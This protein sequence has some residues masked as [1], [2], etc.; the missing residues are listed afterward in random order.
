MHRPLVTG[1]RSPDTRSVGGWVHLGA[2]LD[3]VGGRELCHPCRES[4]TGNS[5]RS[6]DSIPIT[7]T[8]RHFS[9]VGP[10]VFTSLLLRMVSHVKREWHRQKPSD[11]DFFVWRRKFNVTLYRKCMNN[12]CVQYYKILGVATRWTVR[13]SNPVGGIFSGFIRAGPEIH[14]ASCT[15]VTCSLFQGQSVRGVALITHP[16][17]R[18][19][20]PPAVPA[21]HVMGNLYPLR[22]PFC[23]VSRSR[24]FDFAWWP[25]LLPYLL[26][27]LECGVC[28]MN[29]NA[30]IS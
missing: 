3:V 28:C 21:G 1:E 18:L 12:I 4:N 26:I 13:G 30:C 11:L 15:T 20:F 5:T 24:A 2:G 29:L 19:T 27:E 10:G 6:L 22:L 23:C 9:V 14:P 8:R 25:S 16:H 17:S 7:L